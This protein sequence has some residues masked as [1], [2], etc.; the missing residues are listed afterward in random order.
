M[1]RAHA[2]WGPAYRVWVRACVTFQNI[3][4]PVG[5]SL[6]HANASTSATSDA[7]GPPGCP[8][9]D[10][11]GAVFFIAMSAR[12]VADCS[13]LEASWS[14]PL[15]SKACS[16]FVWKTCSTAIV[17]MADA[18]RPAAM[19]AFFRI[20][21]SGTARLLG[22]HLAQVGHNC[23]L[24]GLRFGMPQTIDSVDRR[25]GAASPQDFFLDFGGQ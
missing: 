3:F 21:G 15:S 6:S 8:Y 18:A 23:I 4:R 19:I 20:E 10:R 13:F 9:C 22:K 5:P 25:E 7:E 14:G 2:T 16:I 11:P 12:S 24:E 1:H 17:W